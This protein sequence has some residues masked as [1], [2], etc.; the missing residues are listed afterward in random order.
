ML[1]VAE[2]PMFALEPALTTVSLVRGR[3]VEIPLQIDRA[4]GFDTEIHFAFENL[5]PGVTADALIATKGLSVAKVRLHASREAPVG[6]YAHLAILGSARE[7][8][9]EEAPQISV[10]VE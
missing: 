10:S 2:R 8:Q 5:P 1:A 3:S 7:G 6:K 9:V 4:S